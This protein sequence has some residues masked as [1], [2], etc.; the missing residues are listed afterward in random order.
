ME[1]HP[2]K[3]LGALLDGPALQPP[4]GVVPNFDHPGNLNGVA[5][6]TNVL[7]LLVTVFAVFV[8]VY[9]LCT[10][11]K[12]VQ[13]EDVLMLAALV[14]FL[15]AIWCSY[16]IIHTAGAFTHQW[17]IRLEDLNGILYS[18]HIGFNL[19]IAALGLSKAAILTEWSRIFVPRGTRNSFYWACKTL[20]VV[21][22]LTHTGFIVTE[23]LSCM[24][25]NKIWNKTIDGGYCISEAYF[26]LP[27]ALV[28]T[29]CNLIILILPHRTIWNLKTSQKNKIGISLI[30]LVG[31]LALVSSIARSVE[32]IEF[33]ESDDKTYKISAVYLW[34]LAEMTCTFLAFCAPAAPKALSNMNRI[35]K[36]ITSFLVRVG[37]RK[38][39]TLPT[40][41]TRSW[42]SEFPSAKSRD[43]ERRRDSPKTG[44]WMRDAAALYRQFGSVRK[45]HQS[46]EKIMPNAIL[47]TTSV[48]TK[49]TS[50]IQDRHSALGHSWTMQKC[51]KG[52]QRNSC[53]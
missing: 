8:R 51:S 6:L 23:N 47:V 35:S 14:N 41:E 52:L 22:F 1:F 44:C 38:Q 43:S 12:K 13:L 21:L 31:V 20:L 49:I 3:D 9:A 25:H 33:V 24:P 50:P 18:L 28:N 34:V 53:R 10:C 29:V 17:D 4:P 46:S 40:V 45:A 2:T 37:L 11:T 15:A 19:C 39:P 32:T 30:F 7:C 42:P 16:T 5:E 36:P 48:S 26:H 27:A